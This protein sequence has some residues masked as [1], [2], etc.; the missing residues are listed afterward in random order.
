MVRG[1]EEGKKE[2]GVEME[3]KKRMKE[4]KVEYSCHCHNQNNNWSNQ[5]CRS[6]YL[7]IQ[8]LRPPRV[9][10]YGLPIH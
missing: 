2:E 6:P 3:E 10:S 8:H 5:S 1:N 7:N 9:C 4:S